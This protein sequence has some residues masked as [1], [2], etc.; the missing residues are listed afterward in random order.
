MSAIKIDRLRKQ[1]D[2]LVA[3]DDTS[4]EVERGET[5]GLL[6]PN[7]AGK[8]TTINMM[9]GVLRPDGGSVNINGSGDP[10]R[11]EIRK[12]IGNAPQTIS[13]YSELTAEE[14]LSFFGKLYGLKGSQL[15]ERVKWGLEFAGLSERSGDRVGKFSGGMQ[16]RLNLACALVHDPPILLLDEPTVGVDPQSRNQIFTSIE[17]LASE[18]RTIIYTTHYMEEAQRLC[19][20][21]AIIDHGKILALDNVDRLIEQHG[22]KAVIQAELIALPSDPSALPGTLDGNNLRLETTTPLED[23]AKLSD[24]GLRFHS[25]RIERADL[26][27]VFL[28]LTGRRLRD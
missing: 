18:G 14:N 10:T 20:R 22:G 27:T 12:Q 3:V 1:F 4:F 19:N 16:R 21:V 8:T 15:K 25:M 13:L 2:S 28:N 9:V 7:G 17:K 26:E 11:P 6:G 23:L 5:F 24:S